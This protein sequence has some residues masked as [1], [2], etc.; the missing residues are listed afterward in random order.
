MT[1]PWD[2]PTLVVDASTYEGT[3]AVLRD[4]VVA[5]T[6]SARMRGEHE[7]RLLPAVLATMAEAGYALREVAR[8][9][10]GAGP[11]SF[12]SL[13]IAGA[14][15]KG[16]AM[17]AGTPLFAVPS[18]A[19]IAAGGE[20]PLAPGRWLA[21]LD[22]MRDERYAALF[23]VRADGSVHEGERVGII[24]AADVP[25]VC[26]R[27][28]ARP[29]GPLEDTV[30]WPHAR[31]AARLLDAIGGVGPVPL[32]GWEPDYGRLAEAQVKWEAAHGR[33]LEA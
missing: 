3:V 23:D 29:V 17:G 21:M 10:C 7:E 13:R 14:I 26:E 22:A 12:T 9:V 15:A 16:A 28:Q 30:G 19:L 32:D 31:G 33:V 11:G 8:V 24:A 2:G 18:L 5:A 27:L 6:G 4:G 25:S 1:A 20:V